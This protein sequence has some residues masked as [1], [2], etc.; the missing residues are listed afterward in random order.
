MP[1][2]V[3]IRIEQAFAH[4]P[5]ETYAWLTDFDDADDK[6]AGDVLRSRKVISKDAK[7]IVYEGETEVLGRRIFGRS[8]VYLSPPN[9]WEARVVSGPRTGSR[10]DYVVLARPG[11]SMARVDYHFVLTDPKKHVLLS[12]ARLLVKRSLKRMWEGFSA[13]MDAESKE[14][15]VRSEPAAQGFGK[16]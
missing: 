8:E 2:P 9:K 14:S 5:A 4:P 7:M 13:S 12:V 11:G 3:H 1:K 6:R 15:G 16:P 10:T